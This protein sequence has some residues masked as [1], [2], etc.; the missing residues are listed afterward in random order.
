MNL[1]TDQHH[2]LQQNINCPGCD[3]HFVKVSAFV[4]H[5]ELNRCPKISVHTAAARCTPSLNFARGLEKLDAESGMPSDIKDFSRFLNGDHE[6]AQPAPWSTGP[7]TPWDNPSTDAWTPPD[8]DTS[9]K[10]ALKTS[11]HTNM[12]GNAN[13]PDFLTGDN[14]G[15]LD[16]Q[17]GINPWEWE[18]E[19]VPSIASAQ[20][21]TSERL[22]QMKADQSTTAVPTS[23]SFRY[24]MDDPDSPHFSVSR[25]FNPYTKKYRCP[26]CT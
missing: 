15:R 26:K 4:Q 7:S 6:P 3:A 25:Y 23:I 9:E 20:R 2:A 13:M 5:I 24:E 18:N 16:G 17:Q 12:H 1:T 19:P 11:H 10:D 21:P 8:F 14:N 22:E